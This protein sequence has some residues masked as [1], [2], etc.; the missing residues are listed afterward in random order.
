MDKMLT[1]DDVAEF[2]QFSPRKVWELVKSGKLKACKMGRDVRIAP[3]AL[4]EFIK[5][6]QMV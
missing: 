6:T 2:L 3:E 1:Y 4:Q 5:N